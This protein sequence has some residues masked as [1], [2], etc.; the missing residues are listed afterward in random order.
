MQLLIQHLL[1]HI[2]LFAL[3]RF[4]VDVEIYSQFPARMVALIKNADDNYRHVFMQPW[5]TFFPMSR[6]VNI[7]FMETQS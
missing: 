7:P 3:N 5:C 1:S 6:E 4:Q 2:L